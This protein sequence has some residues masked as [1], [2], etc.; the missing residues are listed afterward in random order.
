[1]AEPNDDKKLAL[2]VAEK[3]RAL[4]AAIKEAQ[5]AGLVVTLLEEHFIAFLLGRCGDLSL[6]VTRHLL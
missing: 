6:K 3:A 2:N 5:Q 4:K 1:M